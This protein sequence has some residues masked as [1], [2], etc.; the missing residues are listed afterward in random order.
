VLFSDIVASDVPDDPHFERDLLAYFPDRMEMKFAADIASHRLRR[1]IIARVVANDLINRGGPSFVTRLM[2]ATGRGAREVVRAFAVVR[3]GFALPALYREIDALDNKID[4]QVQLDL[5]AAVGRLVLSASAWDLKNGSGTAALGEQIAAL[6]DARRTLEPKLASLLPEFTKE[7]ISERKLALVEAG[8]PEKLAE[9]LALL[10]ASALI[11]DI[12]LVARDA[13]SDLLVAAKAFFAISD[14]FRISR[15]EDAAGSIAPSD[16]YEGMALSRAVDT[17]GAARR[18][19]AAAALTGFSKKGDPVSAW[20]EAG[21][22]RIGKT[23][24]R[25]QVLTEGG[26]ITVSRLT[27]ASGLMSDLAGL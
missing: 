13:K 11:P 12:A 3:D 26:D 27:V 15:I 22:E 2:D 14:T 4:G 25:L 23:R 8:T 1:E 10:D 24:E 7:R 20:L 16:Y 17:I 18:G 6:Q 9:R 21:G 19:M 5:Y